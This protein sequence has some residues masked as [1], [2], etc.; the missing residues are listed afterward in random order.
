M[1]ITHTGMQFRATTTTTTKVA[2]IGNC[3]PHVQVMDGPNDPQCQ[4][5]NGYGQWEL[6]NGGP[7]P[8]DSTAFQSERKRRLCKT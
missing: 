5:E 8:A 1:I 6:T 7:S 2:R 3:R 4:L